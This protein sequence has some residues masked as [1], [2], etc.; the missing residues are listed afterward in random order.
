LSLNISETDN[1]LSLDLALAVRTHFRLSPIG[2]DKIINKI[3]NS[4]AAWRDVAEQLAISKSEQDQMS[5]AFVT[6]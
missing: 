4:V 6:G 2:A 3:R 5:P 1:S